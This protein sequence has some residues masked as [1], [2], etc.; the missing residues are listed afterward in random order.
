MKQLLCTISIVFLIS[1]QVFGQ[2]SISAFKVLPIGSFKQIA[3]PGY[4]FDADLL[5]TNENSPVKFSLGVGFFWVK[6]N[7]DTFLLGTSGQYSGFRYVMSTYQVTTINMKL[8]YRILRKKFSPEIGVDVTPTFYNDNEENY[9][10]MSIVTDKEIHFGL[11][12]MPKVGVSYMVSDR[13]TLSL[14]LG[15]S[16]SIYNDLWATPYWK[17]SLGC[18]F[19]IGENFVN[20]IYMNLPR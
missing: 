4:G 2:I 5:F 8:W 6:P 16:I 13:V 14:D 10:P 17:P 1:T 19:H 15:R 9:Q 11:T 20:P 3:H 18:M 7:Q 12:V